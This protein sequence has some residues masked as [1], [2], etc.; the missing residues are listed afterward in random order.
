MLLELT[1]RGL[2]RCDSCGAPL[3]PGDQLA[4]FC[5]DCQATLRPRRARRRKGKAS[6]PRTRPRRASRQ[7]VASVR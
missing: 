4:G 5:E 3:P 7:E 1:Y 6:R 2:D